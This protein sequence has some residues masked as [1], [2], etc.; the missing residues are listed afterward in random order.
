MATASLSKIKLAEA[1]SWNT[2]AKVCR[3]CLRNECIKF[4]IFEDQDETLSLLQR[5]SLFYN[6]K[7]GLP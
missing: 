1:L 2:L 3:L 4:D 5:I 7:V 6:I